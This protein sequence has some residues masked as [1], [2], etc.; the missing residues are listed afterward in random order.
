MIRTFITALAVILLGSTLL[1]ASAFAEKIS[2][3]WINCRAGTIKLLTASKEAT[4]YALEFTGIT[5][6]TG[7][8]VFDNQ[9]HICVGSISI[10][11]G[12]GSGGGFC[13]YMDPDGDF[14]LLEWTRSATSP[15]GT[16]KY[17]YGT[18]KW[19]GIKGGGDYMGASAGKPIE[20]GTLQICTRAT[21]SYELPNK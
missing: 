6:P 20:K 17:L 10:I 19:K 13:K 16:W 11:N 3:D 9:T 4:V 2:M 12:K 8:K 21:G 5:V 18:G 7:N 1:A 15:A 14:T